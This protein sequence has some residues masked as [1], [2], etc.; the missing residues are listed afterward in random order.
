MDKLNL[1]GIKHESVKWKVIHFLED[2]WS[3]GE[4]VE[5][6]TG[7]SNKMR[8]LVIEVLDEYDLLYTIGRKFYYNKNCLIVLME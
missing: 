7:N 1:H 6:V 4:E 8:K 5:I 3:S 2:N